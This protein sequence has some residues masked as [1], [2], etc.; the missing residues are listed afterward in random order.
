MVF[1]Y[2]PKRVSPTNIFIDKLI[3]CKGYRKVFEKCSGER[4]FG[5]LLRARLFAGV[6]RRGTV[7]FQHIRMQRCIQTYETHTLQRPCRSHRWLG[8]NC[9]RN[10]QQKV[11]AVF[12][13][14]VL[15]FL[16]FGA[17]VLKDEENNIN[18]HPQGP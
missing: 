18:S 5:E 9:S 13:L 15:G 10:R 3:F 1:A 8:S 14:G 7:S 6:A 12:A 11:N 2:D 16:G 17:T 4:R